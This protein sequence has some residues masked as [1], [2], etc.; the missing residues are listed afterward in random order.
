MR[1]VGRCEIGRFSGESRASNCV[2]A[3]RSLRPSEKRAM[4]QSIASKIIS[5]KS[6]R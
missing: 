3:R 1:A 5:I 2:F 6:I 4:L